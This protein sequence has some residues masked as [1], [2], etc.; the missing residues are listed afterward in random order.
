MANPIAKKTE[1]IV[2]GC[3]VVGG[4]VKV[5][6]MGRCHRCQLWRIYWRVI[7]EKSA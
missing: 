3:E 1:T 5:G 6:Q 4:T 7:M 2:R